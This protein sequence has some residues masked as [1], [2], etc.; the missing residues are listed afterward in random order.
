MPS[1]SDRRDLLLLVLVGL[2]WG[3]AYPV[4]RFGILAG[5]TP[6]VFA[7]IRYA[8]S[9]ALIAAVAAATRVHR[10]PWR[11]FAL[12]ALLGLPIVG[13]YGLLLYLG[14]AS[15][16]GN[17]SAI[18]IAG[19]PFLTALFALR[20]LPGESLG[21]AGAVGLLVGFLGVVLL[22][23]PPPGI[24]LAT[25]FW[26]PV[27]VL[28]AAV[29]VAFGTVLLR[30]YRPEGETLWGVSV[31][32]AVATAFLLVVLPV[33][34]PHPAFPVTRST[35]F[36]LA[37][38]VLLPSLVGYSIYFYLHHRVGPSRANL[39]AYVN[40]VAAV[41]IGTLAFAEPFQVWELGGFAL[42]VVGLTILTRY[43]RARPSPPAGAPRP[44]S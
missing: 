7:D 19:T 5:A 28:G 33:V 4:I 17:L 30:R 3:S 2:V 11:S 39:V 40:P 44:S 21:R 25:T 8:I 41:L 16:S 13:V 31:Q 29:S 24:V 22:V 43:R 27:A 9:A 10:P 12:S 35:V 26:G 6:V 15:T 34:E 23:V 20:A 38:L 37:Y 18:L 42:V 36:A 1:D 32:F 14:E